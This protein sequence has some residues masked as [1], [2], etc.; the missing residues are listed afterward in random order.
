VDADRG[1]TVTGQAVDTAVVVIVA[2]AGTQSILMILQM[3]LSS[4]LIKVAV[5]VVA[6][7]VTYFIVG[8]LKAIRKRGF[9]RSAHRS[10]SICLAKKSA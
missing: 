9:L 1:S 5:E 4:Y 10:Q 3:I 7:P 8:R 6:K 2:F